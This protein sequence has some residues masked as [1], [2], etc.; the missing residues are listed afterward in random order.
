MV[1]KRLF[2]IDI[3]PFNIRSLLTCSHSHPGICPKVFHLNHLAVT[4]CR[5]CIAQCPHPAFSIFPQTSPPCLPD[6]CPSCVP[7]IT[8][9]HPQCLHSSHWIAMVCM[10]PTG[11][12]GNNSVLYIQEVHAKFI[13]QIK[14]MTLENVG[15]KHAH[16]SISLSLRT[17]GAQ[18]I[19]VEWMSKRRDARAVFMENPWDVVMAWMQERR[20]MEWF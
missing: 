3:K 12:P 16:K 14:P 17:I 20:E 4:H 6:L 5:S 11:G 9:A 10:S 15:K 13:R 1:G 18:W 8:S 7:L 2:C 19:T